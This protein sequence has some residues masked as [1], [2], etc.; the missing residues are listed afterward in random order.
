[1]AENAESTER[2]RE[3]WQGP[4]IFVEC[5]TEI[6]GVR[7]GGRCGVSALCLP[8]VSH[9]R[10]HAISHFLIQ[11]WTALRPWKKQHLTGGNY[12]KTGLSHFLTS[13]FCRFTLYF[14][15]AN[16]YSKDYFASGIFLSYK[17]SF[18]SCIMTQKFDRSWNFIV[19]PFPVITLTVHWLY[20]NLTEHQVH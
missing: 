4:S 20:D 19:L 12:V 10:T 18:N 9:S 16:I 17:I 15:N 11:P 13:H 14:F 5:E 1:M 6:E 3:G 2:S 8:T 7:E